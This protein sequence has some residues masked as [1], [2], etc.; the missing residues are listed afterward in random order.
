M[1]ERIETGC[2]FLLP[3]FLVIALWIIGLFFLILLHATAVFF[4]LLFIN[5][6]SA[7]G[8]LSIHS[9]VLAI[10]NPSVCL[11][12]HLTVHHML[13]LCQNDLSYDLDVFTG[14]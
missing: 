13:L 1:I 14:G 11:S 4:S 3:L 9:T 10:V 7:S 6:Y 5:F 8:W 2:H 12:V